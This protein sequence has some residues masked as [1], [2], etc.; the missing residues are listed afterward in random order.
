K[1]KVGNPRDKGTVEKVLDILNIGEFSKCD[2]WIGDPWDSDR[3]LY[4]LEST[5]ITE[6][7]KKVN[8]KEISTVFNYVETS[9][10]NL[11]ERIF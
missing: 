8:I 4:R 2:G 9:I 11:N 6:L 1:A 3:E 10:K 5:V 7:R